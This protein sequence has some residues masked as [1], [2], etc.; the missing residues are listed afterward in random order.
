MGHLGLQLQDHPDAGKVEPLAQQLSD[1][2]QHHDVGL[3]VEPRA[4]RGASRLQQATALVD[5]EV[6]DR[7]IGTLGRDRD[8]KQSLL[9]SSHRTYH[10][11]DDT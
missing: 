7:Q 8:R 1:P 10:G 11:V 5:A 6:L 3:A 9:V 2:A 4:T